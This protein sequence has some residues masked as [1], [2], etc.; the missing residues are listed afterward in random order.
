M[1]PN[2]RYLDIGAPLPQASMQAA[3]APAKAMEGLSATIQAVGEKGMAIAAKVRRVEEA[4]KI[5]SYFAQLDQEAGE[6]TNS[7]LTRTDS[8]N[9]PAEWREKVTQFQ[10]NSRKLD[11]S[12]E[13]QHSLALQVQDWSGQRT[14]RMESLAAKKTVQESRAIIEN[15]INTYSGRGEIDAARAEA[16]RLADL[17]VMPSEIEKLDQQISL[18]G[19]RKAL[20]ESA[21]ANP[22]Q[23]LRDLD[24]PDFLQMPGNETLSI[25]DIE[26]A[27]AEANQQ[28]RLQLTA[29]SDQFYDKLATGEIRNKADLEREFGNHFFEENPRILASF[30]QILSERNDAALQAQRSTPEYHQAAIGEVSSRLAKLQPQQEGFPF[31][32]VEIEN[33]AH[34]LPTGP[35]RT[36]L[37]SLIEEKK[38]GIEKEFK[39]NLELAEQDF[40]AAF[41]RGGLGSINPQKVNMNTL[42]DQGFLRDP[43]KMIADGFS[44]EQAATIS[45]ADVDKATLK[46]VFSEDEAIALA[47]KEKWTN[48]DHIRVYRAL[49]PKRPNPSSL[50]GFEKQAASALIDGDTEFQ[51]DDWSTVLPARRKLGGMLQELREW[52]AANPDKINDPDAIHRKKTEIL[53]RNVQAD[54]TSSLFTPEDDWNGMVLPPIK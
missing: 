37:F 41:E 44:P 26:Y 54:F 32:L 18:I 20:S 15:N 53:G 39:S 50:T 33:I 16:S 6:F 42:L 1:L 14:L 7:L 17:G 21:R 36:H 12:P 11:L 5:S 46:T 52:A 19:N 8:Q 3:L 51:A 24:S 43:K 28:V 34:T 31:E 38:N 30:S 4:G 9:W 48:A 29:A 47:D 13:A 35:T 2:T 45:Q 27:R 49:L 40:T 25:E 23:L 10:A 22:S